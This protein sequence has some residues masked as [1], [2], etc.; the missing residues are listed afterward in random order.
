VS[1][2]YSYSNIL[3]IRDFMSNLRVFMSGLSRVGRLQVLSLSCSV[4]RLTS[5]KLD[6]SV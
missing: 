1:N 6:L 3:V 2:W 5:V 4:D